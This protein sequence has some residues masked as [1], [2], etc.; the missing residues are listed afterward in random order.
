[1]NPWLWIVWAVVALVVLFVVSAVVA[2]VVEAVKVTIREGREDALVRN[3]RAMDLEHPRPEIPEPW[4]CCV[5]CRKLGL[6]EDMIPYTDPT[7][8]GFVHYCSSCWAARFGISL[9]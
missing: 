1:M 9:N 6:E 4:A 7:V 8:S 2:G 5:G 3:L